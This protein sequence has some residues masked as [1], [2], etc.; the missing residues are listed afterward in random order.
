MNNLKFKRKEL[1]RNSTPEERILWS[2]L[3]GKQLGYRF[4]RQHS[5]GP[6]I[7]DFYCASH[8]LI[9]EIDGFHHNLN[10]NH[11]YDIERTE[12]LNSF[13]YRIIRFT[14]PDIQQNIQE[15]LNKIKFTL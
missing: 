6:Y 14:N 15:V 8:N 5:I 12:F 4:H 7:V 3:R 11:I 13:N 9:V 1:R 10:E 2:K